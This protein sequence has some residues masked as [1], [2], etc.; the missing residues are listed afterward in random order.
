MA[1]KASP[2]PAPVG[3]KPQDERTPFQEAG[4]SWVE[5]VKVHLGCAESGGVGWA[6]GRSRVGR[7][8]GGKAGSQAPAETRH[9]ARPAWRQR[10]CGGN[11]GE[12][13]RAPTP[14]PQF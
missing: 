14:F 1:L 9:L 10:A 13:L 7:A 6:Y 12:G 11:G 2:E 4:P 3:R 5:R 8:W